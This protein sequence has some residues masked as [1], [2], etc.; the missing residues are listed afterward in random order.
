MSQKIFA[1]LADLSVIDEKYFIIDF[2]Y[3]NQIYRST[4]YYIK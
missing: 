2:W 1:W 3:A 4:I